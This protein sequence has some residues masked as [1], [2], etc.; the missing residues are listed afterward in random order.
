MSD[1]A[2][3]QN[4]YDQFDHVN[5]QAH[6][7]MASLSVLSEQ[8]THLLAE[9]AKL[10]VENEHLRLSITDQQQKNKDE[11]SDSRKV[12]EQ[13]Y[14]KGFHVCRQRYGERLDPYE[15]CTWCL[16]VIYGNHDLPKG[17]PSHANK[18]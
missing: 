16:D 9:N 11:L 1:S 10:S 13:L 5:Q 7:L 4:I 12:L 14:L 2:N 3:K 17:D 6:E 18:V 15:S 8:L